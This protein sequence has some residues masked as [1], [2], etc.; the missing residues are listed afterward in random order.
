MRGRA[1]SG[2]SF[3]EEEGGGGSRVSGAYP[4]QQQQQQFLLQQQQH[5]QQQQRH[6]PDVRQHPHRQQNGLAIEPAA[7]ASAPNTSCSDSNRISSSPLL[8]QDQGARMSY[9]SAFAMGRDLDDVMPFSELPLSSM[10]RGDSLGGGDGIGRALLRAELTVRS[11]RSDSIVSANSTTEHHLLSPHQLVYQN[12][13]RQP[14]ILR[15]PQQQQQLHHHP[16]QSASMHRN[17]VASPSA[18]PTSRQYHSDNHIDNINNEIFGD[19]MVDIRRA[20]EETQTAHVAHTRGQVDDDIRFRRA[21][22]IAS[23][24]SRQ[25]NED[26]YV[27]EYESQLERAIADSQRVSHRAYE[28]RGGG[29]GQTDGE[30]DLVRMIAAQSI[31]DEENRQRSA[32]QKYQ[33]EMEMALK[34]SEHLEE[35]KKR[36]QLSEED[37]LQKVLEQ[38]RREYDESQLEEKEMMQRAIRESID[39]LEMGKSGDDDDEMLEEVLKMSLEEKQQQASSVEEEAEQLRQALEWS[40]YDFK[41]EEYDRRRQSR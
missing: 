8:T 25:R 7:V 34:Q 31:R 14:S 38:T 29:G 1:K 12:S 26:D 20:I 35:E 33:V 11:E 3:E 6:Y 40:M 24:Q 27:S 21:L 17:I 32:N 18:S 13:S 5:Q 2:S 23:I 28:E 41:C 10:G 16:Y 37:L 19:E 39:S 15:L 4:Q 36:Q 9:N 22:E 30:D